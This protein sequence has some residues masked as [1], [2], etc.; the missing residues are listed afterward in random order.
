MKRKPNR[1]TGNPVENAVRISNL[2]REI[3]DLITRADILAS[4]GDSP[5]NT[6]DR[7]GRVLF[8]VSFAIGRC[9][10]PDDLPEVRI[11]RAMSNV[12]HELSIDHSSLENHRPALSSG[13]QA[14]QR[15]LP[16]LNVWS[17]GEGSLV[18]DH[19][20]K[21]GRE[22]HIQ[23]FDQLMAAPAALPIGA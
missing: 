4:W 14:V 20:L 12:V 8:I 19:L 21:Q 16:R 6:I 7:C 18:L 15:L 11:L 22:V 10:I 2:K 5:A 9:K 17:I 1:H 13:L 23:E 3:N